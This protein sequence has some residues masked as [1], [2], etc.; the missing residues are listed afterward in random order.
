[1]P[2]HTYKDNVALTFDANKKRLRTEG[3]II[4]AALMNEALHEMTSQ[5]NEALSRGEILEIG[6]SR[7]EM[8]GF[9]R[10]AASRELGALG[11][12]DS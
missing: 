2:N 11:A 12:G 8:K 4:L 9:L 3:Q 6:G 7:E 5:F 1:M 10:I